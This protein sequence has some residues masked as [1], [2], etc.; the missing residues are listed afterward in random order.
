M[1]IF[2]KIFQQKN[3]GRRHLHKMLNYLEIK[4]FSKDGLSTKCKKVLIGN[5]EM[6]E[7]V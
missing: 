6:L 7:A 4:L 3:G 2:H 1:I 5:C